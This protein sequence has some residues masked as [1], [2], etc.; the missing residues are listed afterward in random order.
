M[1]RRVFLLGVALAVVA[2]ALAGTDRVL[3]P[4]LR[5]GV[6]E[7]N[8]Q[9]LREWMTFEE[10]EAIL[11]PL[12]G[13]PNAPA[14]T[15]PREE[16]VKMFR[17]HDAGDRLLYAFSVTIPGEGGDAVLRFNDFGR[18]ERVEWQRAPAR[19]TGLIDRLRAWLGW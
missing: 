4:P 10:V 14:S 11:G 9:R 1:S 6:T 17:E 19:T 7:R 3:R 12:P 15:I 2:L 16:L 8:V 18:F 13:G 5:P